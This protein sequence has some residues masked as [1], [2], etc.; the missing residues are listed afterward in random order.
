[1]ADMSVWP[2]D[3]SDGVVATEARWRKMA[4]LWAPSAV[5][6][7]AG[8][9]LAPTLAMPNLTIQSGACWLDGHYTEL[10]ASTVLTA[11]ANGLAVARV[12]PTINNAEVVWRDGVTTPTQTPD[13]VWELPLYKTVASVGTDLRVL[14]A[15]VIPPIPPAPN[16]G[17][18]VT[19]PYTADKVINPE[20]TTVTEV[21]RVLGTLIDTLKTDGTLGPP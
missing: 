2:T 14:A 15:A 20:A 6:K 17:W 1:M 4:R 11:T 21:A 12:D 18:S 8:G 5:V 10:G 13:G 16:P 3:G 9:E 19:G 7:G